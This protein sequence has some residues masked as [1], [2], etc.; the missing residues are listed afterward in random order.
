MKKTL[1][2]AISAAALLAPAGAFACMMDPV[3]DWSMD[4]GMTNVSAKTQMDLRVGTVTSARM[5][6]DEN[7]GEAHPLYH[8]GRPDRRSVQ[9]SYR[10]MLKRRLGKFKSVKGYNPYVES[11]GEAR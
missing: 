10:A 4:T 6:M 5:S 3:G 1:I 7:T 2:S 9:S 8:T 11:E